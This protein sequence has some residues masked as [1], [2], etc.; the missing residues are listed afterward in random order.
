M[1]VW[2]ADVCSSNL[3]RGNAKL[4]LDRGPGPLS[5]PRPV[6]IA[7]LLKKPLQS[8]GVG[9]RPHRCR[10]R[11]RVTLEFSTEILA[12]PAAENKFTARLFRV[13]SEERRVGK[14]V[15][16]KVRYRGWPLYK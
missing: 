11:D 10:G 16:S 12:F 2:G 8:I 9:M 4:F 3:G 1:I 15:V 6:E 5:L 7:K 13:R 14:E